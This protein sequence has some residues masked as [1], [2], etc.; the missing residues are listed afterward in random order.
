[1]LIDAVVNPTVLTDVGVHKAWTDHARERDK[2]KKRE[3]ER[4]NAKLAEWI[5]ESV[6]HINE[7]KKEKAVYCWETTGLSGRLDVWDGERRARL[8]Q[9][10]LPQL[11][12]YAG[13]ALMVEPGMLFPSLT[14]VAMKAA[15]N[16]R[17]L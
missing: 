17:V 7:S 11:S 5:S 15:A 16:P 3:A 2:A 12:L 14:V 4:M 1:M 6:K 8:L 10:A 9:Q 13:S